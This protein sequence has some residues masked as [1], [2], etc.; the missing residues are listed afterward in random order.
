MRCRGLDSLACWSVFR[1]HRHESSTASTKTD[2]SSGWIGSDLTGTMA[3][4][5][6]SGLAPLGDYGGPTQTVALLPG[7]PAVDAGN[8][9]LVPAGIATVWQAPAQHSSTPP[10]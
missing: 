3:T 6:D 2:G 10:E 7:S 8:N 5:L 4:P 9:A 1:S